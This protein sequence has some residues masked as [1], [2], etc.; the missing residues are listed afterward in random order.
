MPFVRFHC[1]FLT[2][3]SSNHGVNSETQDSTVKSTISTTLSQTLNLLTGV[4]TVKGC[5]VSQSER[6]KRNGVCD[7]NEEEDDDEEKN[8]RTKIPTGLR[9]LLILDQVGS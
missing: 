2:C 6:R 7:S 4:P 3:Y 9:L 8:L 1:K 5:T